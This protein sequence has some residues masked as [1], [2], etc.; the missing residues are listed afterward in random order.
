MK[1]SNRLSSALACCALLVISSSAFAQRG[2]GRG[3][4][5]YNRVQLCSLSQV[6]TELKLSDE[7]KKMAT[8]LSEKYNTERREIMQGAQGDF[9]G[10]ME[11]STKLGNEVTAKLVEKLDDNQKTRLMQIFV[12]ANT[13]GALADPEIQKALKITDEQSKKLSEARS[14]NMQ[15]M[16]EAF[17]G[18]QDLSQEERQKKMDEFRKA[19]DS[20]IFACISADQKAEFDKLGGAKLELDLSQLAPRRANN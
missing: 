6:Q 15:A 10:A 17:A 13:S 8:E 16:R 20:K 1:T 3:M 2:G 7:Q 5:G 4:G 19:S 14:S 18:S 9:Q 11:K 12:Q